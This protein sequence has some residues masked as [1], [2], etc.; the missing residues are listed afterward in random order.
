[1][2]VK[3]FEETAFANVTYDVVICCLRI[4]TG[5]MFGV[6]RVFWEHETFCA[7]ICGNT[8]CSQGRD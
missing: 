4:F 2:T 3:R 1:L 8:C 6:T 7:I 5:R